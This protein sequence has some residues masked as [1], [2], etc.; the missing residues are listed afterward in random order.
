LSTSKTSINL[1][2]RVNITNP[3]EYSALIPYLNIHISNNG[4]V[5]GDATLRNISVGPGNNTNLLVL[6]TWDPSTFGGENGTEI[7]RELLS[8]YISGFNTTLIFQTHNGSIP[9][10]PE[11]GSTLSKFAIEIP[12]PRLSTPTGD[13]GAGG[14]QE[15]HFIED[16]T[17]HF[18]SSTATFTLVSPLKY[19]T[20][21]IDSINATALYNHTEPI[22]II[23]YDTFQSSSRIESVS[24]ATSRL[25]TGLRW[26]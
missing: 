21:Y 11:I 9:F 3:T 4:S 1:R 22:G 25:V 10:Q 19:S 12:T 2:A 18:S 20:I 14:D 7:G 13:D 26:L 8:Q 23:N 16:S 15:P 6:A 17:F 24:E 5:L